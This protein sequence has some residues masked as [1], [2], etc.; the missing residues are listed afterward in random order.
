MA[1]KVP[2]KYRVKSGSFGSDN[3]FGCNGL[4]ELRTNKFPIQFRVVCSDKMDWEHVSV[5]TH[6][7]TPTWEEM[8]WIKSQFWEDEDFVMQIHP[9]KSEWINNHKYCLHL[10]RKNGTNDFCEKPPSILVG[11]KEAG[12]IS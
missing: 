5:S 7:R 6:K 4:F 9:P 8:C 10:F 3:S 11:I 12:E 2:E 1:M